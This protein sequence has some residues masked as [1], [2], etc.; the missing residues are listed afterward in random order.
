MNAGSKPEIEAFVET[1]SAEEIMKALV[2]RQ[3]AL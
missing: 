1:V 3:L 2:A